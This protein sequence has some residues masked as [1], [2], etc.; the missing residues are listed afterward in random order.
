MHVYSKTYDNNGQIILIRIVR[1]SL[2][3]LIL[4][5]VSIEILLPE[6][7]CV[8][9]C[10]G[11][12]SGIP[13]RPPR[14]YGSCYDRCPSGS[15]R[16]YEDYASGDFLCA[17]LAS[18]CR[19]FSLTQLC[20]V[21]FAETDLAEDMVYSGREQE[22]TPRDTTHDNQEASVLT[23]RAAT[24]GSLRPYGS[25]RFWT[26]KLPPA[27]PFSY[28]SVPARSHHAARRG[29][30]PFGPDSSFTRV[31][32]LEP[33]H[34]PHPPQPSIPGE[35]TD[36][37]VSPHEN[38]DRALLDSPPPPGPSTTPL[39]RRNTSAPQQNVKLSVV[40]PHAKHPVWDDSPDLD[41][42]YENPF[43]VAPIDNYL[44]LPRNPFGVLDLD[45]SVDMH[46]SLTSEPGAG[47]LG[48]WMNGTVESRV[49]FSGEL[50]DTPSSMTSPESNHSQSIREFPFRMGRR[51]SGTEE[52]ALSSTLSSRI[53]RIEQEDDVDQARPHRPILGRSR[54]YGRRLS[55]ARGPSTPDGQPG[56]TGRSVNQSPAGLPDRSVS[57][58]SDALITPQ[59]LFRST[60]HDPVNEPDVQAQAAF[61]E[62]SPSVSVSMHAASKEPRLTRRYENATSASVPMR[63]AVV[64][65]VIAEEQ[66]EAMDRIRREEEEQ[67]LKD[68]QRPSWWNAWL[69]HRSPPTVHL[70]SGAQPDDP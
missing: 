52:I 34:S 40:T 6:V 5:H 49:L 50:A 61:V 47:K 10:P 44:W 1:Y 64:G 25:S 56:S 66:V 33:G 57:G 4:A 26:W 21:K 19:Y 11:C 68:S 42:P 62:S 30:N 37:K 20:R 2:D 59:G 70:A 53:N 24:L 35:I 29:A 3:G 41:R 69:W 51:L 46:E 38:G 28:A 67:R 12:V 60:P 7:I 45:D 65:E 8:N 15:H 9:G 55:N 63:E 39:S 43:Y 14:N 27:P 17:F 36:N 16:H 22:F 18:D 32:S 54:S 23:S 13:S 48:Q 58:L 31:T